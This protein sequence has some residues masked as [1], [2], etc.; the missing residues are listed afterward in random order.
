MAALAIMEEQQGW[1]V[2]LRVVWRAGITIITII[3][4]RAGLRHF[5]TACYNRPIPW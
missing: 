4:K 2:G 3:T 5:P 1:P